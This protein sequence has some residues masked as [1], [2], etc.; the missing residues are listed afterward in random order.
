MRQGVLTIIAVLVLSAFIHVAAVLSLPHLAPKD[1]WARINALTEPNRMMVLPPASAAQQSIPLMAPDVRYAICR[2]DLSNGPVRLSLHDLDDLWSITFYT[3]DA[4]NFYAITG[5]ELKRKNIE[6]IVSPENEAGIKVGSSLLD[7]IEDLVVVDSPV[8][9]GVAV[10]R[11]PLLGQSYADR[12]ERALQ[13]SAC[14]RNLPGTD[15]NR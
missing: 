3:S 10:V 13:R 4:E 9:E 1:A 15:F 6:I 7:A 11:A 2:F 14:S 12:T 8:R 5:R